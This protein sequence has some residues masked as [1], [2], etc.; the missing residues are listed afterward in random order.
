MRNEPPCKLQH[1]WRWAEVGERIQPVWRFWNNTE[2]VASTVNRDEFRLPSEGIVHYPFHYAS[3]T[4]KEYAECAL[5][6][7]CPM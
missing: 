1:G 5:T 3:P 4:A 7:S 6:E 2:L